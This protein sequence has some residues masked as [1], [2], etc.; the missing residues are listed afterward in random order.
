MESRAHSRFQRLAV[1]TALV[2]MLSTGL[3]ATQAAAQDRTVALQIAP[4]PLQSALLEYSRATN[5]QIIFS[6]G[7]LRGQ[8]TRGARGSYDADVA[9]QVLLDGTDLRAERTPSGAIQVS[10][11][12]DAGPPDPAAAGNV[13]REAATAIDE[14]VVTGT[15]IRGNAPVGSKAVVLGQSQIQESGRATAGDILRTIP[16]NVPLGPSEE[17]QGAVQGILPNFHGAAGA[18]L[19]GLGADSTLSLV[20]GH[21]IAETYQ[22]A[23]SDISQI[24][25]IALE[26]VEVLPDGASA[27]YGSDAVGGVVNFVLRSQ[28][29]GFETRAR[30]GVGDGFEEFGVSQ[31]AGARWSGGSAFLGVEYFRRSNLAAA[32]RE[33]YTNDLRAFGG[34]DLRRQN[35]SPGNIIVAGV[36]YAIPEGQNGR[37]L[38]PSDLIRG[39]LN[40]DNLWAQADILPKSDRIS[41]A[42]TLSHELTPTLR[43]FFDGL[44]ARRKNTRRGSPIVATLTVPRTNPFF[45]SPTGAQTTPVLY[46]F[47]GDYGPQ[48]PD[49][50]TD[51]FNVHLGLEKRLPADWRARL[52]VTSGRNRVDFTRDW[53]PNLALV[54]LALAD[55]N[56][57]TAFNPFGDAG[58]NSLEVLQRVN[59]FSGIYS[60]LGFNSLNFEANGAVLDLPA[61][62]V[63]LAFGGELRKEKHLFWEHRFTA[64]AAPTFPESSADRTIKGLFA[65]TV[66]PLFSDANAVT[67]IRSLRLSG[68]VRAETYSGFGDTVN[69]KFG[70]DWSPVKG[71]E[72]RGSWG[73]SFKA[74]TLAQ[75]ITSANTIAGL[76]IVNA[77]LPGGRVNVIQLNGASPDL[78]P[79]QAETLTLGFTYAPERTPGLRFSVDY[80][81]VRY[82][83]RILR[84]TPLEIAD[85]LADPS[86]P[87][88]LIISRSPS[89]QEVAAY[90]A[91]P[92][93]IL[94]TPRLPASQIFAV[95]DFREIN[96]G[97]V[98]QSGV[99]A[100]VSY[101]TDTELGTFSVVA[102]VTYIDKYKVGRLPGKPSVDL[103][104]TSSNPIDL[105]GKLR[106]GWRAGNM[107]AAVTAYYTDSYRNTTLTPSQR[108]DSWT[109]LDGQLA[110]EFDDDAPMLQNLRL[111]LDVRNLLDEAPPRVANVAGPFGYDAE[112]ASAIGRVVSVSLTKSW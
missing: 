109:T 111:A 29:D 63:R 33:Y 23:F 107:S 76:P 20:N 106:L 43:L 8:Q 86:T 49:T 67:G 89:E 53:T 3:Y 73:T 92:T 72:F 80:F 21:R 48:A 57:S 110:Y 77:A 101:V 12:S 88:P 102:E 10:R 17:A 94:S 36:P 15:R 79:Q 14:L 44:A 97:R 96:I 95:V 11:R 45:V 81:D 59:G 87:S 61:G 70:V 74:P 56:P 47:A 28:L 37:G 7:D 24:P 93:Y 9:L 30:A 84:A 55:P 6:S 35:A 18:N 78:K 16:Q 51:D 68:A 71:L 103:L 54:A 52:S 41:A 60:R 98:L 82:R 75:T 34:P 42:A 100:S 85:A 64:S 31:A 108:V 50:L 112:F 38:T 25:V 26:R 66:V 27:I 62:P 99:D 105:R 2:S 104:N 4:Q 91:D 13:T 65:E 1:T 5:R 22:G 19:R 46:S 69:P 58:S 39:V 32:D 90:Y 40:Q 83:D